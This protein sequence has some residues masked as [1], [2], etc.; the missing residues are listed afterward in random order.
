MLINLLNDVV[1]VGTDSAEDVTDAGD[2]P[3]MLLFLLINGHY[4]T[5]VT[6]TV[7]C[8]LILLLLMILTT[9]CM[10]LMFLKMLF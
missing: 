4:A 9:K 10:Q 8:M 5:D 2:V 6:G 7:A 3:V 1:D